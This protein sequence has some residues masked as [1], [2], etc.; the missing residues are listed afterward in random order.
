MW[1]V[2]HNKL[3]MH[4]NSPRLSTH[5]WCARSTRS[6]LHN[7]AIPTVTPWLSALAE[8]LFLQA[9]RYVTLV[10]TSV[11]YRGRGDRPRER[12]RPLGLGIWE[13]KVLGS[14]A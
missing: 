2:A 5:Y 11:T 6:G 10:I 4:P 8:R 13:M 7:R 12:L 3:A 9:G 14:Y 1:K